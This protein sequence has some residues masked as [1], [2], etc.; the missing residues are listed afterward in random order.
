MRTY[1]PGWEIRQRRRPSTRFL[2]LIALIPLLTGLFAAPAAPVVHG[3]ELQ[4]AISQRKDAEKAIADQQ[5]QVAKLKALQAGLKSDI[6]AT[7]KAL[8]GVNADLGAVKAQISTL[9]V[10]IGE[11]Q[12]AYDDLV[13]RLQIVSAQLPR[14]MAEEAQ[15][16]ADLVARKAELAQRLRDAYDADRTSL[17]ETFLSSDSFTDVLT[18]VGYFLDIGSQDKA[19]AQEIIQQQ[20]VLAAV[21]ER[22]VAVRDETNDLKTETA[23]Q[24]AELDGQMT[25]L[26]AARDQLKVL[27]A[28]TAKT[29]AAQKS[30]YAKIARN[31][32]AAEKAVAEAAAAE[33]QLQGKIDQII[34]ENKQFGNIPSRF[35]GT[36]V[37]PAKGTVTQNFGCTGF[38][39]EPPLGSCKH[40]HQGID[41]AAPMYTPITA[42]GDGTVVFAGPN[43]WDPYPK[44]WIV[45]IAH[46]S[47]LLTWYAHIDN[48]KHP[49]AVRAGQQ[50]KAGQVIAY[51]GMTGRTTGPHLHWAVEYNDSF[52]NPRLFL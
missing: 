32:A 35:N 44:A 21:H 20:Q 16:Q 4:D 12:A 7:K 19:L 13:L 40:F 33:R 31:K 22:V 30:A 26:Q 47:N 6:A 24:K 18:R 17:L 50:V 39:W 42:S 2:L 46:S 25:D 8:A 14:I 36:L 37:W 43:P 29:L 41:I 15:Q 28:Q 34:K 49:P 10:K 3:D 1:A 51:V 27:Q 5:A 38:S 48:N 11:V 52:T 23:E 45:I 9:T